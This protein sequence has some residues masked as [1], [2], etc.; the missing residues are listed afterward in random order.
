MA[1][2]PTGSLHIGTA[3]T[4]LFNFL[5]ARQ[6][7]GAFILRIENTDTA[8]STKESERDI[9]DGFAWLGLTFDEG[10][11]P[12]GSEKGE[13]GP[14]RQLDRLHIYEKYLQKLLR[15]G[16]AYYCFCTKEE[17]D[18][19][20]EEQ[21]KKK[22]P[23]RY[24]GTCAALPEAKRA[25]NIATEK[26]SV[27]RFKVPPERVRFADLIRGEVE[28]NNALS[29]DIVIAKSLREPLYN[30][31]VVIDDYEMKI[32]HIVRGEEHLANT[33]KQ[34]ALARALDIAPPAYA[35]LPLILSAHGKGKMSKREGATAISEYRKAGYL[36]EAMINFLALLGWHPSGDQ[37]LFS[38]NELI[39]A[40]SLERISKS[41]AAFNRDKLDYFNAHYI[42]QK[43]AGE[44]EKL[45]IEGGF[46]PREWAAARERF[47]AAVELIR[48]RLF[49]L[50]DFKEHAAFLFELPPYNAELLIWQKANA[51]MAKSALQKCS[52]A[53]AS[54]PESEFTKARI[55]SEI[56]KLAKEYG[57]GEIFWPLRVALSGQKSSPPPVDILAVLWRE[58]S[59]HRIA[60]AQEKLSA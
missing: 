44:L 19:E 42:K 24:S 32:S 49:R 46:A 56:E 50:A 11:V 53:L 23:P 55:E 27:I 2:S 54:I 33:P 26:P 35:H 25:K 15:N 58:E 59:L 40:F 10:I 38:I 34:I 29:D 16:S 31:A 52:A 41:G 43:S 7:K 9:L 3:R 47:S 28:F 51:A 60:A 6:Q 45:L 5:F 12:D 48:G 57:T 1:P 36:P 13:Y 20:R 14:Y 39:A 22:L 18:A 30:F 8:R 21:Q 37:E 4:A 17:L